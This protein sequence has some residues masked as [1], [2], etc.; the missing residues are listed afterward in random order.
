[1]NEKPWTYVETRSKIKSTGEYY[2]IKV[3]LEDLG[4]LKDKNI[5]IA[6]DSGL[7][8]GM[9]VCCRDIIGGF[10]DRSKQ[11]AV[12]RIILNLVL[13][14]RSFTIGYLNNNPLDLRKSNL[15]IIRINEVKF[16]A[17]GPKKSSTLPRGVYITGNTIFSVI[18]INRKNNY[19]GSFNTIEEA[20]KAYKD[21]KKSILETLESVDLNK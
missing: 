13:V 17:K 5:V 2:K 9:L 18:T 7:K 21:A 3:D 12:S 16:K 19:L 8:L 15:K 11:V 6:K 14:N 4:L 10:V 1:M 20:S